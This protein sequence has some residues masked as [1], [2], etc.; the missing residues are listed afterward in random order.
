MQTVLG[1]DLVARYF[2]CIPRRSG[3]NERCRSPRNWCYLFVFAKSYPLARNAKIIRWAVDAAD[4]YKNTTIMVIAATRFLWIITY[5]KTEEQHWTNYFWDSESK[6][7]ELMLNM[8]LDVCKNLYMCIKSVLHHSEI[9]I[10]N[11]D[12][13]WI[14]HFHVTILNY[15]WIIFIGF[16]SFTPSLSSSEAYSVSAWFSLVYGIFSF[17]LLLLKHV[18]KWKRTTSTLFAIICKSVRQLPWFC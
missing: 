15:I 18:Y 3:N 5:K 16:V 13:S 4:A 9:R 17:Y 1:T 7:F 2:F 10:G 14:F 6:F 11:A 12:T 8:D